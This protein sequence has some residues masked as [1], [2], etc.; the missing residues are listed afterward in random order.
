M[1]LAEALQ[2]RADL[3]RKIDEIKRRL[4]KN[5]LVQ[6]GEQPAEQ[7]E[8]L[9]KSLDACIDRL[10]TLMAAINRTNGKT[11]VKGIVVRTNCFNINNIQIMVNCKKGCVC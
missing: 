5:I 9:L 4:A 6:E 1:K 7:P 10:E 2:E 11:K 3:N 8:E